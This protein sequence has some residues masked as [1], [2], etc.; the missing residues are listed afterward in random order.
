MTTHDVRPSVLTHHVDYCD[1]E[2]YCREC[3]EQIL[4]W[5]WPCKLSEVGP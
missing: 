4:D 3:S 2:P 1:D 5:V